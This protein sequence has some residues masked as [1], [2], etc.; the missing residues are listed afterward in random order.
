[1]RP[2]EAGIMD[3]INEELLPFH[4]VNS[5]LLKRNTVYGRV[6]EALTKISCH[7]MVHVAILLVERGT[8]SGL[9]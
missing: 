2:I 1:M 3:A 6:M 8:R 9:K 4:S 7:D 5:K